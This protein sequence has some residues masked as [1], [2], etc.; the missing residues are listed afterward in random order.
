M[1]LQVD[2]FCN[3]FVFGDLTDY[4][5]LAEVLVVH[6]VRRVADHMLDLFK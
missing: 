4:E 1:G 5:L 2:P 3:I 6:Y